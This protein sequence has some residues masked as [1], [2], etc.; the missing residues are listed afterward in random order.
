MTKPQRELMRRR[1]DRLAKARKAAAR[2]AAG[3]RCCRRGHELP[4]GATE[5]AQCVPRLTE[6]TFCDQCE[7]LERLLFAARQD[8]KPAIAE[9]LHDLRAQWDRQERQR[10]KVARERRDAQRVQS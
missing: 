5:C 1:A 3:I 10:T 7:Q 2:R 9:M 8:E 6:M 4:A